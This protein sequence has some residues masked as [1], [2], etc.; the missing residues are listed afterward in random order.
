MPMLPRAL[1]ALVRTTPATALDDIERLMELAQLRQRLDLRSKTLLRPAARRHFPFPGANTT[2][3]Q[4]EGV[5]RV[6]RAAGCHS[7]VWSAPRP[8]IA[9]IG[10]GTDLNGYL[11]LLRAYGVAEC[12]APDKAARDTNLALLPTLKA[13]A[14]TVIGGALGCLVDQHVSGGH[15]GNRRAHEQLVDALATSRKRHAGIFAVM[16]G[17]TAGAGPGPYYLCPEI[18][19]VLLA[20]ADPLALDAVAARLMGLDPLRHVDYLRLAHERGLGIADPRAIELAGDVDLARKRWSFVSGCSGWPG[21]SRLPIRMLGYA[22]ERLAWSLAQRQVFE[23]W[24]R[25]TP[26]GQLFAQYQRWGYG[27]DPEAPTARHER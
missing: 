13:D 21:T 27:S 10:A 5:L 22:T 25:G 19:N 9:S 16:D 15:L 1:V 2:P 23:S 18:R 26:W 6:L 8:R 11:P 4:L 24:L 17:T 3:W 7:L 12:R 20:S 14:A